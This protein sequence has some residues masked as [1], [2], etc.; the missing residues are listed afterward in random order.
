MYFIFT[1]FQEIV[2]PTNRTGSHSEAL[3]PGTAE[4]SQEEIRVDIPIM[5][6]NINKR[7]MWMERWVATVVA[8]VW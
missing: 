4:L 7:L 1:S 3:M 8:V 5:M 2:D 6:R